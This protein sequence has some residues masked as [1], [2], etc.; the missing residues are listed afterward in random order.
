[1]S[2]AKTHLPEFIKDE[3]ELEE[4]LSRP[5]SGLIQMMKRLDGDLIFLGASGKIGPDLAHTAIRAVKEAQVKKKIFGVDLFQDKESMTAL[6]HLDM[7]LIKCDLLE[8]DDVA[9]LP[10]VK[11][12]IYLA[13]KKFGTK[14]SEE[15]TWSINVIPPANTARH[16]SG[17]RIVAFSTGCVYPLVDNI[18]GGCTEES[19][20]GPVGEYAQS[21]LGR[22]R[23][24][25]SYSKT[26]KTPVSL[27]RLS[28]AVDLRYGVLHDIGK[29]VMEEKP[30]D[31][32]MSYFNTIWQGDVNIQT[33]LMLEHCASPPSIWN[34]TRPEIVST[35]FVA[36][37]Y[38]K[39]MGKKAI[40][41][42]KE[43]HKYYLSDTSKAVRTFG[44]PSISLD[45]LI[46]W[47][48]YWLLSGRHS[49]NKPTHFEE[50]EG[51]F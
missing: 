31:L 48:A 25:G 8:P 45:T 27:I 20:C 11:N 43:G 30:I 35:R 50:N 18:N 41:T 32:K 49:L 26:N 42:G 23:I 29:L 7:E 13:G 24:F 34:I 4:I 46:R 19:P 1:M 5:S 9:R 14:G 21:C 38:A 33:L 16:F 6:D 40:F 12:V 28:Y 3:S 47:Q 22:E 39:I 17:S 51:D 2:K 37:E 15:M 36:E 44:I 10:R